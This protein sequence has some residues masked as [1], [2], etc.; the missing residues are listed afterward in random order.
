MTTTDLPGASTVTSEE[1]NEDETAA[2]PMFFKVIGLHHLLDHGTVL[3]GRS[4]S[5]H[6][7]FAR[8]IVAVRVAG[9]YTSANSLRRF[10]SLAVVA[11]NGLTCAFKAIVLATNTDRCGLCWTWHGIPAHGVRPPVLCRVWPV[12]ALRRTFAVVS[13]YSTLAVWIITLLFAVDVGTCR[14]TTEAA[15]PSTRVAARLHGSPIY[16]ST[17]PRWLR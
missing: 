9:L 5:P 3:G 2:D 14:L 12:T 6:I 1:C 10:A 16:A 11:F 17:P 15:R 13:C 7:W 8:L 4:R